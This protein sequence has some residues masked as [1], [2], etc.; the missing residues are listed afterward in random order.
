MRATQQILNVPTRQSRD[1]AVE[2]DQRDGVIMHGWDRLSEREP[3]AAKSGPSP[4]RGRDGLTRPGQTQ[5]AQS[6]GLKWQKVGRIFGPS[7]MIGALHNVPVPKGPEAQFRLKISPVAR[8][9]RPHS[10]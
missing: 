1:H 6:N 2:P 8:S 5:R 4:S 9:R 10:V 7:G 3:G